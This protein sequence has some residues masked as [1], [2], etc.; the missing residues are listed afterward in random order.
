NK[1]VQLIDLNKDN[2]N[3]VMTAADLKLFSKGE[4]QDKLAQKYVAK[5][6]ESDELILIFPI[7][8]YGEPAILKGFYDKVLLKHHTY[9]DSSGTMRGLLNINKATI[10]TTGT[11][12]E[13]MF[14]H[15]GNPILNIVANGIL[16]SIGVNNVDWIH[17][18]TVHLKE[19]R[20]QYL[21][22]INN[23]FNQ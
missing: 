16:K 4:Y 1:T 22:R 6:K 5:L 2:F 13:N 3:P 7:W 19:A 8:W 10:L 20:E 15:F 14:A 23:Y 18:P 12:D 17:C 9:D 21:T 11:I